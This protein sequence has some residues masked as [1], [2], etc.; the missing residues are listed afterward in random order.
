MLKIPLHF[1]LT[2]LVIVL[3]GACEQRDPAP[4]LKDPIYLDLIAQ[5]SISQRAMAAE[6]KQ[7]AEFKSKLDDVV[8]QTKQ[9]DFAKKRVF[10]SQSRMEKHEQQIKYWKIR[11]VE[12]QKHARRYY[13]ESYSKGE[14]WP[15]PKEFQVYQSEK[16]LRQS[17]IQWDIRQRLEDFERAS[18]RK[19]SSAH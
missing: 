17:K 3:L 11:I 10:E 12:R 1:L 16:R 7:L 2:A 4:E 6:E 15:N 9:I 19:P 13:N 5:L 8:P 14:V 18:E